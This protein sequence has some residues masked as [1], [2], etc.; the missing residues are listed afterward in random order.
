[1]GPRDGASDTERF[2]SVVLGIHLDGTP[3]TLI[4]K[5]IFTLVQIVYKCL[6]YQFLDCVLWKVTSCRRIERIWTGA[7]K[8][9]VE[10]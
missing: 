1:M 6:Q 8:V 7:I 10:E 3:G 9:K 5:M 2:G 4:F